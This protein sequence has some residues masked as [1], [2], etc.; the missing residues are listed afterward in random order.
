MTELKCVKL[1]SV[2]RTFYAVDT[3]TSSRF[4]DS[5]NAVAVVRYKGQR[6]SRQGQKVTQC[7]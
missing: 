2:Q 7:Y 3:S 1:H 5:G 6:R 4:G